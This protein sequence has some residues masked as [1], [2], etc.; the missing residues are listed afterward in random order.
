MLR[1][2]IALSVLLVINAFSGVS[3]LKTNRI[4]MSLDKK[5]AK[6]VGSAFLASSLLGGMSAP[7]F[8]KEGAPAKIGIFTNNDVS[9]PFAAGETREDPLYSPYSPY[10]NGEKA[11]YNN[12][13]KNSADELK[14]WKGKFDDC[15]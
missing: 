2:L 13:R 7:S 8:A 11:V 15:S 10:G 1:L 12:G 9:S 4:T 6:A 5:I 14:F 3:P